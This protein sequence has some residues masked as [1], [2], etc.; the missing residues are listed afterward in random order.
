MIRRSRWALFIALGDSGGGRLL[1][2]EREAGGKRAR[3]RLVR[4]AAEG[5]GAPRRGLPP[6]ER[7]RSSAVPYQTAPWPGRDR[8]VARLITYL[9]LHYCKQCVSL[10]VRLS[11]SRP[12]LPCSSASRRRS[13]SRPPGPPDSGNTLR[14]WSRPFPKVTSANYVL[15][16]IIS[17]WCR[18][19]I[20]FGVL[21]LVRD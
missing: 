8:C 13:I 18:A 15:K 9:R 19:R 3:R 20:C 2:R 1:N 16:R 11:L 10:H 6:R 7:V 14:D 5:V 17:R 21:L 12:F 4:A